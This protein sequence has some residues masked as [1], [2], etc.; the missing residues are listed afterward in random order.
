M[1]I[2][3]NI[4]MKIL[5]IHTVKV[6]VIAKPGAEWTIQSTRFCNLLTAKSF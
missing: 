5:N 2:D 6:T 1:D 4:P 3:G